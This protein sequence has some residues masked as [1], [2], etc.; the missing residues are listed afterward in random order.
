LPRAESTQAFVTGGYTGTAVIGGSER[1]SCLV[2][3]RL[4]NFEVK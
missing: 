4:M 3:V 1:S 2:P